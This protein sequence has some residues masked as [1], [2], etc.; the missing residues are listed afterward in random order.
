[1]EASKMISTIL[2]ERRPSP[3]HRGLDI[4]L[5]KLEDKS[6]QIILD[7]EINEEIGVIDNEIRELIHHNIFYNNAADNVKIDTI[8]RIIA[9]AKE[10]LQKGLLN[11][12]IKSILIF[13]HA[14]CYLNS[15][16]EKFLHEE[17]KESDANALS[18]KILA[19]L[20]NL[21]LVL[22]V[23][24]DAPYHEKEMMRKHLDGIANN[25]IEET[26]QM[27][28][29]I[30]NGR[31]FH[32]N[33]LYDH[34]ILFLCH[35]NFNYFIKALTRLEH[36]TEM[37]FYLQEFKQQDVLKIAMAFSLSNNWLNFEVIRQIIEKT[38]KDIVEEEETQA[39]KTVLERIKNN[40]FSFLKKTAAYF[41]NNTLFNAAFGEFLTFC[42]NEQ[43]EE[44][45]SE[46]FKIDRYHSYQ[47]ARDS[48]RQHYTKIA[49]VEQVNFLDTLVFTKWRIY[50]A[51]L[52]KSKEF[53]LNGLLLTDFVNFIILYHTRLTDEQDLIVQMKSLV[54]K[55]KFI[56]AEWTLSK[57]SQI[58][59]FHL[60]HSE[61]FLL[62]YAYRYKNLN[63]TVL[64]K[65]Y[66]EITCNLIQCSRYISK[67]T[68]NHFKAARQNINWTVQQ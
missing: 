59:L 39:I 26:Y 20:S 7:G 65:A 52:F 23:P 34:L 58:T 10:Y 42:S 47:T 25:D 43:I 21:K 30:E 41:H 45:I 36:P 67:E 55:I 48:M 62:T 54:E 63:N 9:S 3:T 46:C 17:I 37:V 68:E 1:M 11:A 33:F 2:E 28:K 32:F 5:K 40:D 64:L 53:Y 35:I 4:I 51:T 49:S 22:Q 57:S 12:D 15:G 44:C 13:F 27:I 6:L 31:G 24:S 56:D 66:N 29:G 61:L 38:N 18:E 19:H 50:F 8:A 60:Y 16:I 14:I